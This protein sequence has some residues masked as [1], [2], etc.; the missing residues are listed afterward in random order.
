MFIDFDELDEAEQALQPQVGSVQAA[1]DPPAPKIEPE[2]LIATE[3]KRS[4][5]PPPPAVAETAI[6]TSGGVEKVRRLLD[7]GFP[8]RADD[9]AEE[10]LADGPAAEVQWALRLLRLEASLHPKSKGPFNA[11]RACT[12]ARALVAEKQEDPAASNLLGRALC[13]ACKR[14][15]AED[16]WRAAAALGH[17]VARATLRALER[18]DEAKQEGNA[19]FKE[20]KWAAAETAYS[21]AL[22]ADRLQL[23]RE[24]IAATLGNRSAARRKLARPAE[25]LQDAEESLRISPKYARARFRKALALADLGRFEESLL[26]L[27]AVQTAD[28]QVAGLQEW[29]ARMEC[30][31]K[32]PPDPLGPRGFYDLLKLP[33]DAT[34][35]EVEAVRQRFTITASP[36]LQ[37]AF[38]VLRDAA[39]REVYDF[40]RR[41]GPEPPA[42][43]AP[44]PGAKGDGYKSCLECGFKPPTEKDKWAHNA[45]KGHAGFFDAS[46]QRPRVAIRGRAGG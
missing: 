22:E 5:S 15:E 33:M 23:D 20:G 32:K 36:T 28:P 31:S 24:A 26:E 1:V 41:R 46:G 44:P 14:T 13:M 7:D 6:Q 29:I 40:G 21:R 27:R 17:E 38:E 8:E 16:V 18:A 37:Q 19:A 9:L 45:L 12:Q 11:E 30:W 43:A 25:A 39:K 3:L 2:E 10:L 35:E 34:A 4:S 42:R